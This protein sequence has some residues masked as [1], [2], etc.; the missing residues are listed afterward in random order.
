MDKIRVIIADDEDDAIE[1]LS[2]ILND[3]G[4]VEILAEIRN[5]FKVESALNKLKPDALFL[6]IEMPGQNGLSLLENIREYNPTL[7]VIYVSAY[8][9]YIKD[10]IKLN[11]F[12]YLLKPVDRNELSKVIDKLL[13]VN[14]NRIHNATNTCKLK[15]PIQGGYVYL[16]PEE[17]LLLEAEGNYTCLKT[18]SGEEFMSSYNMGRLYNKLPNTF[19]RINRGCVLNGDFIYRVNKNNNTCQVRSNGNDLELAISKAFITEFNKRVL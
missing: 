5:S 2:N 17:L 14:Y 9:K 4:K 19:F 3:T 15:L 16:K 1:V 6:D 11:V 12:S 8:D 18:T 7:P 10:V 13:Q